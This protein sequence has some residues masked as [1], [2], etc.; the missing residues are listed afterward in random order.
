MPMPAFISY[1]HNDRDFVERLAVRLAREGARIWLDKWELRVGDSLLARIQKGIDTADALLVVLSKS[2]VESEW[3]RKELSSGL[4]KELDEKRVIVLPILLEDCKVPL[5]LR[6]K[7]YADFRTSFETGFPDVL[8][9]ITGA[10]SLAMGRVI[11]DGS[12]LD[13]A[14]RWGK[15][16]EGRLVLHFVLI[17]ASPEWDY[18]I[19]V[20]I[21]I[22]ANPVATHRYSA[23]EA[24]EIGWMGRFVILESVAEVTRT[25]KMTVLLED[26][27]PRT[28]SATIGDHR[29]GRAYNVQVEVQRLGQDSGKDILVDCGGMI[30]SVWTQTRMRLPKTTEDETARLL[31]FLATQ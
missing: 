2:S 31:S 16:A 18:S 6:D 25:Q 20:D 9:A 11:D 21:K 22:V 17:Q 14:E 23:Y 8:E 30:N 13:W 7:V 4:I 10:T 29:N 26:S 27:F 24:A 5:F 15:D 3:C 28:Q 19:L 1:S 12:Y